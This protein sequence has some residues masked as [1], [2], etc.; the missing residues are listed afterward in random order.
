MG[1]VSATTVPQGGEEGGGMVRGPGFGVNDG[2][3]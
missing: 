2:E 1:E 3:V